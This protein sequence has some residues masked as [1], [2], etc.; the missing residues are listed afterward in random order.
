MLMSEGLKKILF[1]NGYY[2]VESNQSLMIR[3]KVVSS[4]GH[5][6]LFVTIGVL[7]FGLGLIMSFLF[8]FEM[9][10]AILIIGMVI[11]GV[12]FFGYLSAPYRGLV[13]NLRD[14]TIL[15]RA[16]RSRAYKFGEIDSLE[17][18]S[19]VSDADT[20]AFSDSNKEYRYHF[21][22][23]LDNGIKEE[24]FRFSRDHEMAK[25]H[26]T[27]LNNFFKNLLVEKT[28]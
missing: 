21:N 13:F 8:G 12:P 11:A 5:M 15:F 14:K 19:N 27:E 28:I 20:N 25:N 16:G 6:L 22:L 10:I 23:L 3:R 17:L 26:S 9:A 24:L 1:D 7:T 4:L 2:I 18:V